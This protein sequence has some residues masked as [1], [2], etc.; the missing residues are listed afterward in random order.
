M[1][2]LQQEKQAVSKPRLE[3]LAKDTAL[4]ATTVLALKPPEGPQ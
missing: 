1:N 4:S 2:K 3:S